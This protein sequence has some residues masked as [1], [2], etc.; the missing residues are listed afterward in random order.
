[1]SDTACLRLTSVLDFRAAQP[2]KASLLEHRGKPLELDASDVERFGGLCLQVLAAAR[3]SWAA[4]GHAFAIA[5]P[6]E[7][8]SSALTLMG[9]AEHL[10]V[11][12]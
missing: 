9:G 11:N 1:M 4:E 3:A 10:G 5:N 8:F 6:S 2:L 7:A 12:P